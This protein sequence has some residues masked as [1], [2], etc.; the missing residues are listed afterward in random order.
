MEKKAYRIGDIANL[1]GLSRDSLR[2]Y[3]KK[4]ILPAQKKENGYRYYSED[5]LF[6]LMYILCRRKMNMGLDL[7][8]EQMNQELSPDTIQAALKEQIKIEQQKILQHQQAKM[9][10]QMTS[11][12]MERISQCMDI[13]Q[14]RPFPSAYHIETMPNFHDAIWKYFEQSE[15]CKGM[16]MAYLYNRFSIQENSLQPEETYLLIYQELEHYVELTKLQ[17]QKS[18]IAITKNFPCVYT[19]KESRT[20]EPSFEDIQDMIKW[21]D[22]QG[23][24]CD[25]TVFANDMLYSFRQGCLIHYLELYLPLSHG[26]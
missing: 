5:D 14:I 7:I 18:D 9:R 1:V 10:L 20:P 25:T 13:F 15:T 26:S 11:Q 17:K 22:R 2:F 24:V 3:E 6:R 23:L 16:D 4:G 8:S 12:D 21:A 19:I